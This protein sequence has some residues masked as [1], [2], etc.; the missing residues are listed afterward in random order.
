[1]RWHG[2][3]AGAAQRWPAAFAPLALGL[4]FA[5]AL[6]AAG[7]IAGLAA[8]AGVDV[9][10]GA[11]G[12]TIASTA[13]QDSAFV[14]VAWLLAAQLG[15]I[16]AR[17][18][19]LT[20]LPLRTAAAWTIAAIAA[21]YAFTLLYAAL[22]TPVGKQDTLDALGANDTVALLVV[23]TVLVVL[24]APFAEEIFFRGFCYRALRNR[25]SRWTAA[26]IVGTIFS[27]IHYSGPETLALL[28]PLAVLGALFCLLYERTGS[29]YP[30]IAL[31]VVNNA[32]ALAITAEATQAPITAAIVAILALA[33][34]VHLST[35]RRAHP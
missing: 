20:R 18:L 14:A 30:S 35:P 16:S 34:C 27:A 28:P 21:W 1:M 23:T 17:D 25:F 4:A 11:P 8:A 10:A 13:A 5:L 15:P 33:A 19:G 2:P 6:L 31:H 12:V 7:V 24:V 26:V 22:L 9:R 3:A 32:I 29:L